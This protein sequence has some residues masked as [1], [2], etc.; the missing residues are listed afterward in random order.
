MSDPPSTLEAMGSVVSLAE[1]RRAQEPELL[2]LEAAVRRL[3][4]ALVGEGRT[5]APAWLATEILAIQGC[6]SLDLIDEAAER[7]ERLLKRWERGR[8]GRAG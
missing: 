3:D 8:A 2:R 7:A 6:I 4:R 5:E 1:W